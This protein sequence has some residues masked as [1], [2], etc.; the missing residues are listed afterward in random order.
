MHPR[1]GLNE[2]PGTVGGRVA[3][4]RGLSFGPP[5]RELQEWAR[6]RLLIDFVSGFFLF[7][8]GVGGM[9][10]GTWMDV[11]G[12]RMSDPGG[13]RKTECAVYQY[14]LCGFWE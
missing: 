11:F 10:V 5:V 12:F 2:G 14:F 4:A 9:N 6:N 1:S 13:G 8:F 3:G 7:W